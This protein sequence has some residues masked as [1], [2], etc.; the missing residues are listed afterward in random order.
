MDKLAYKRSLPRVNKRLTSLAI[1][2]LLITFS[3]FMAI[4]VRHGEVAVSV[5]A[6]TW[7]T[8][9]GTVVVTLIAFTRL[10]L[11]RAVLRYLTFHALTVVVLGALISALSITTFAYFFNAEVP[12]TVPVYLHDVYSNVR[13]GCTHD[14]AF[15]K[16]AWLVAKGV[17][18]Y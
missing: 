7:L 3:F 15:I 17:S 16:R 6:E 14:G 2:T 8:L 13:W 9:A 4:W 1:D 10:G 12:R 5:S 11:Y 18:V